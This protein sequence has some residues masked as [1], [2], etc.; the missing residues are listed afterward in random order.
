MANK[1]QI[2]TTFKLATAPIVA[3]LRM[4]EFGENSL[5]THSRDLCIG[6]LKNP[7]LEKLQNKSLRALSRIAPKAMVNVLNS[8]QRRKIALKITKDRTEFLRS[9][10]LSIKGSTGHGSYEV[11]EVDLEDG[12]IVAYIKIKNPGIFISD[13]IDSGAMHPR[14]QSL[15]VDPISQL[16]IHEDTLIRAIKCFEESRSPVKFLCSPSQ[17]YLLE[18]DEDAVIKAVSELE[19]D[20]HDIDEEIKRHI[21]GKLRDGENLKNITKELEV[22]TNELG[23]RLLELSEILKGVK[24]ELKGELEELTMIVSRL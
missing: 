3:L 15:P 8:C 22:V 2:I 16:K 24:D 10:L 6:D 21:I 19:N 23:C 14:E 11:L 17:A 20:D 13:M 12:G 1:S 7:E 9:F 4:S 18:W 5:G